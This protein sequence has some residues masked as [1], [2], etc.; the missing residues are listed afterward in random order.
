MIVDDGDRV[1][2]T[3]QEW[4]SAMAAWQKLQDWSEALAHQRDLHHRAAVKHFLDGH[5]KEVSVKGGHI[6][7]PKP[8]Y[9]R[10]NLGS[11]KVYH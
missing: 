1:P 6:Y 9:V 2:E 10:G 7:I 8:G 11:K 3:E 5:V 4:A